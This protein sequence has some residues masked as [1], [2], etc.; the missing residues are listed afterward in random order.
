MY[1]SSDHA[2]PKS[3]QLT[4]VDYAMHEGI[5]DM[6]ILATVSGV[7]SQGTRR[8]VRHESGADN[9][10][11]TAIETMEYLCNGLDLGVVERIWRGVAVD[12]QSIRAGLVSTEQGGRGIGGVRNE[13]VDGMGH[14]MAEHRE[15]VELQSALILPVDGLVCN[16][17]SRGDHIR[18]H[19]IANEKE[20]IFRLADLFDV[21]DVPVG[22][23]RGVVVAERCHVVARLVQR[24]TSPCF[25]CDVHER[26]SICIFG[27]AISVQSISP[28]GLA[29]PGRMLLTHTS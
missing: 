16:Q 29:T 24:D 12:S 1:V 20:H 3:G 4:I 7:S 11:V 22:N 19:A 9:A 25:G 6:A 8:S 27:E 15:L 14:L 2:M 5:N 18:G 21:S 17:S 13:G 28:T 23:G 26:R 10:N